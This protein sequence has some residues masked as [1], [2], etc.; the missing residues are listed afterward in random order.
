MT[1]SDPRNS[2]PNSRTIFGRPVERTG[3]NSEERLL[4][5]KIEFFEE[6]KLI[7]QITTE[8]SADSF[9]SR[10]SQSKYPQSPSVELAG[11]SG[12]GLMINFSFVFIE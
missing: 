6:N 9:L 1:E 5:T 3:M 10:A 2:D 11:Q 7:R 12:H 4:N 8:S